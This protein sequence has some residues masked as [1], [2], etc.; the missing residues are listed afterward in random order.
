MTVPEYLTTFVSII[1]S[2]AVADLLISLHRLLRA[3]SRVRWYWVPAALALYMLLVAVNFW[4]GNYH[5]FG[6]ASDVSMAEFLPILANLIVLFLLLA[7]VLPDEVPEYGLDLK[8]WYWRNARYF[9]ALNIIGLTLLLATFAATHVRNGPDVIQ[10]LTE[11]SPNFVLLGGA[12]LLLFTRR[13]WVHGIYVAFALAVM[14]YTSLMLT[15]T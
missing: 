14:I 11:K 13:A 9:W 4:W 8:Q 7:A 15:I 3:G 1:V 10:F 12:V 5:T 6:G 2:L